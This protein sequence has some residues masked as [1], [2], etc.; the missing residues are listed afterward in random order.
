MSELGK[1]PSVV[2]SS[3]LTNHQSASLIIT[4][5]GSQRGSRK[6]G[7]RPSVGDHRGEWNRRPPDEVQQIATRRCSADA[8]AFATGRKETCH[9]S[10]VGLDASHRQGKIQEQVGKEAN[11]LPQEAS[12]PQKRTDA[13]RVTRSIKFNGCDNRAATE[14]LVAIARSPPVTSPLRV[15]RANSLVFRIRFVFPVCHRFPFVVSQYGF[16]AQWS[17]PPRRSGRAP[18]THPAPSH[19]LSHRTAPARV[20][21]IRSTKRFGD[22]N[23]FCSRNALNFCQFR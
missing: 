1:H 19:H 8:E 10:P 16:L 2:D 9:G 3:L 18:L 7:R 13:K 6:S 11:S 15:S 4:L 21:A 12:A 20:I 23:G 22:A 14:D 17:S 5:I